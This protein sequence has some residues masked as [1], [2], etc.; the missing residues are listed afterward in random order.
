MGGSLG[1]AAGEALI[2]GLE[3]AVAQGCPIVLL[4]PPAARACRK[5]FFR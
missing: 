2:A 5:A 1:M 4:P 3:T